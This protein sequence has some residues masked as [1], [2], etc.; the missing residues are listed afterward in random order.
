LTYKL[1]FL[2]VPMGG[3]KAGIF[4]APGQVACSRSELMEAFGRAISSLVQQRVYFPGIK[5]EP[6]G[7]ITNPGKSI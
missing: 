5:S 4:A 7:K 2:Y 6:G 3:A 1:V